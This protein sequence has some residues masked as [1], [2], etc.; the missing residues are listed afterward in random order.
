MTSEQELR[1][2]I[3]AELC[4]YFGWHGSGGTLGVTSTR[5]PAPGA[6]HLTDKL[7]PLV[8]A[9]VAQAQEAAWEEGAS[10]QWG[11]PEGSYPTNPYRRVDSTTE[12][13]S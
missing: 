13:G 6:V 1:E 5:Y 4:E 9:H 7:L 8:A 11:C 10:A 3:T 2:A 12:A